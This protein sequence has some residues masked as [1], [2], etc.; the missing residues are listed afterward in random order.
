MSIVNPDFTIW[1]GYVSNPVTTAVYLERALRKICRVITVGPT[2]PVELYQHMGI[3]Q[4]LQPLDI[5]TSFTP[6]MQELA[7]TLPRNFKPDLYLWVDSVA[8]FT[9]FPQH[10]ETLPCPKACYLIDSHFAPDYYQQFSNIFDYVFVA[11][12]NVLDFFRRTNQRSYWLPLACDPEIHRDFGVERIYPV[13]FVGG[14]NDNRERLLAKVAQV[15]PVHIE[16]CFLEDMAQVF[17]KSRIGFNHASLHDLNMRFFELPSTGALQL[18]S[19]TSGSGQEQLFKDGEDIVIYSEENIGDLVRYY[20]SNASLCQQIAERGKRL[21]H[22]AHTYD[23]R[24]KDLLEVVINGKHDTYSPDELRRQSLGLN[25]QQSAMTAPATERVPLLE[26]ATTPP[27]SLPHIARIVSNRDCSNWP[28][29]LMVYEWED[30]LSQTLSANIAPLSDWV[31]LSD[32]CHNVNGYD[33][34]FIQL[35]NN[36]ERFIGKPRFLPVI[37]DLWEN[38]IEPFMQHSVH[39]EL[40]FVT[41]FKAFTMLREHGCSKVVYLPYSFPDQYL[42]DSL[43]PKDVDI[44]QFGRTNPVL[45]GYMSRLLQ[46]YPHL[47][48]VTTVQHDGKIHFHSSQHGL[49]EASD[50]RQ[51]FMTMLGRSTISLV[52]T[53]GMDGSRDTGGFDP[54]SPR[55]Y[56]SVA[57]YCRLIGRFPHNEEFVFLGF[58]QIAERVESYY[59]FEALVLNYLGR[60]FDRL[61]EY[62]ELL[63]RHTTS[64][65]A[66]LIENALRQLQGLRSN[67][68]RSSYEQH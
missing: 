7:A 67:D 21:V 51:K 26:I 37:M 48:Y 35:A 33:L 12:L 23:H 4:E 52:S 42:S 19:Q 18:F 55:F 54:V 66:V 64:T 41:S 28:S 57:G 53:A 38:D 27:S 60:P 63:K 49:L 16:S 5:E 1:L 3:R 47:N 68:I 31:K 13:G 20:L 45:D 46:R 43:P 32:N 8:R 39:F 65:R 34:C 2:M 17:S 10:L 30:I 61:A 11:Q 58:E 15:A 36:L 24:A 59:Q 62:Q 6:D 56:E 25:R 14:M 40:L 9:H 50:T 44:I 22:G 29:W